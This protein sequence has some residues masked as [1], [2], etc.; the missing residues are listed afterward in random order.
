LK[1]RVAALHKENQALKIKNRKL[2]Q[3]DSFNKENSQDSI[4]IQKS[5]S[6]ATKSKN[7]FSG[8]IDLVNL[9]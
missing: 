9:V 6:S 8:P 7:L 4:N 1:A 3:R 5:L 2:M